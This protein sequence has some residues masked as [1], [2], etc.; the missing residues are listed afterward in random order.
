MYYFSLARIQ[1]R[2][3]NFIYRLQLRLQPKVAALA[4]AP[5]HCTDTPENSSRKHNLRKQGTYI[6]YEQFFSENAFLNTMF[7]IRII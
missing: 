2:S 3:L 7:L 5:Q 1:S 4:L 6:L